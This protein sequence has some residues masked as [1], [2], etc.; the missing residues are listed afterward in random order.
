[1]KPGAKQAV[2]ITGAAGGIGQGLV[3]VFAEAGYEVIATAR[4]ADS[5]V[6]NA[7]FVAADLAKTASDEAYAASVFAEV[8]RCLGGRPLKALI[9]NA[10]TQIIGAVE[11]LSRADW[12]TTLDVNVLAPF[13]WTQALLPELEAARGSVINIGSIH[14]KLTKARFAAYSTSKAALNGLTRAM[15]LELGSRVRVNAIEPAAI[16]TPMLKA[17]FKDDPA[18]YRKLEDFHPTRSMGTPQQVAKLALA[19]VD[20]ELPFLNGSIVALDGGIGGVLHDPG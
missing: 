20:D 6:R 13:F 15:A 8:R 2:V 12:R 3:D 7:Q 18:G 11:T 14:S 4:K 16:E 1:L 5:S 10:A 17:G 9:N 19:M